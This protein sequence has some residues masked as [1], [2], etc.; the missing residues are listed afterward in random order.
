[1]K[2]ALV[3]PAE[4]TIEAGT[5]SPVP[6]PADVIVTVESLLALL[7]S[8]TVH[9]VVPPGGRL[10]SLQLNEE[11]LG[12]PSSVNVVVWETLPRLAV[13]TACSST[14]GV[15]AVTGKMPADDPGATVTV[16]GRVKSGLVLVSD[17]TIPLPTAAAASVTMQVPVVPG[18]RFP[19]AQER[20]IMSG[21]TTVKVNDR[22]TPFRLAVRTAIEPVGAEL[23]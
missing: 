13:T 19:G 21:G 10:T 5:V 16:E 2:L 9:C 3:A 14:A 6:L 15:A 1:V 22:E 23:I 11:T 7:E 12:G 4:T 8:E 20:E 17:S 18:S